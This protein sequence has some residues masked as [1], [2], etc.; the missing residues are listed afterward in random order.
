MQRGIKG[1]V[2]FGGSHG[3]ETSFGVFRRKSGGSGGPPWTTN[4]T[5]SGGKKP[6]RPTPTSFDTAGDAPHTVAV[7][8]DPSQHRPGDPR[9]APRRSMARARCCRVGDP[10]RSDRIDWKRG[11]Y[12]LRLSDAGTP[13]PTSEP[14]H[15][16]RSCFLR[17]GGMR[18][19]GRKQR[20]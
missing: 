11:P 6:N 17:G 8:K 1:F 13:V 12:P 16:A 9:F 2:G 20:R 3:S 14:P 18:R 10:V 15:S 4:T 19:V 7:V 5:F